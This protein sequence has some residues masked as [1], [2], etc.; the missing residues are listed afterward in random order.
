M[1]YPEDQK[2]TQWMKVE[3]LIY[4]MDLIGCPYASDKQKVMN[5]CCVLFD[6]M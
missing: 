3:S 1:S 6:S 4:A 5:V 2:Q